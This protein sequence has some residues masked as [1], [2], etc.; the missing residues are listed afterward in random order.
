MNYWDGQQWVPSD[1]TFDAA[2][3]GFVAA[4]VQ[5]P[6][7]LLS[8]LNQIGAVK[9]RTPD[10]I[11]LHSTPV[12]IG[13]YDAASGVS[14]IIGVVKDCSGVLAS[15]NQVVYED[16]FSGVCAD[17]VYTIN[18]GT[19]EQDV[20]ITGRLNPADYG[21]PTNTSRIQIFTEFYDG[22]KPERIRRPLRVEKD[23]AVRSRMA[24][25]DLIDEVL[26]FGE[27]VIGTGKAFT[28]PTFMHTNGVESVVAKE[29]K[30]MAG[31]TF[32][33]ESVEY[34]AMRASL[35]TLPE[36]ELQTASVRSVRGSKADYAA[37][38]PLPSKRDNASASPSNSRASRIAKAGTG[39]RT[40]LVIDYLATL[41]STSSAFTFQGDTTYLVSGLVSLNGPTTIEGGAVVKYQI[42]KS[43]TLTTTST[44][45]CN[46]SSY[47]P[48]IFTAVDDHSVGEQI[49]TGTINPSGY[50]NPA[51]SVAFASSVTLT[52]LQFRYAQESIKIPATGGG[53]TLSHLQLVNCIRGI[54]I[55]GCGSATVTINNSL[56]ANVQ[57]P[58]TFTGS[59]PFANCYNCTIDGYLPVGGT[60]R[61]LTG[62]TSAMA[63]FRNSIIA[64]VNTLS[65]GTVS[66][67]GSSYN[68]F[69]NCG[70]TPFGASQVSPS[71]PPFQSQGAGSYYLAAGHSFRNAGTTVP[72]ALL[73]DLKKKT[74]YP[75]IVLNGSISA[76]TTLSP[77]GQRDTDA[78]DLGYHYDPLDYLLNNVSLSATLTLTN[79]VAVGLQN[80]Y[81]ADMQ[82]G[83]HV[84]S[85]GTPVQMNRVAS[86]ANVQEQPT[87]ASAST[88]LKLNSSSGLPRM[89]F[90]FANLSIGQGKSGTLVD[91]GTGTGNSYPFERLSFRDCTLCNAAITFKP[92]TTS[93]V[94]VAL[95]NNVLDRCKLAI[96][97][98][99]ADGNPNT[100]LT[101][102]LYNNLFRNSPGLP[103][104]PD[105][106]LAL[107]YDFYSGSNPNN[108]TWTARDNL[109]K[110]ASQTLA[111]N[112]QGQALIARSYNGFT[113]GTVNTLAS[114][115]DVTGLTVNF[116]AGGPLGDYYYPASGAY[117]SLAAL[118]NADVG[119]TADLAGL[120]HY[121]TTTAVGTKE[122][123]TLVD[124]GF[125]YLGVNA[126]NQP[127]DTDGDGL[128]DYLEDRDSSGTYTSGD[129]ANLTNVDTDG[130]GLADGY[131]PNPTV[132]NGA[133]GLSGVS[134][135]K[136]PVP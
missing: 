80:S 33:I 97:R 13:L 121:T 54:V 43:V 89:D 50:A 72:A 131:D 85:E 106:A 125:H 48:A 63:S 25:P 110:D 7:H 27:F 86:L 57:Y 73:N 70:F 74:T 62:S 99:T 92:L 23:Q 100:P 76:N 37:I 104:T 136:C 130:D 39:R 108:L 66:T 134:V 28:A 22:N 47:R 113:S 32:L 11:M 64:N 128:P 21:F 2:D 36:C 16:A 127:I 53:G 52:N 122:Q 94:T 75:P 60:S 30:T 42:G 126:S 18:R 79:G 119:R 83:G 91:T 96:S 44:L 40:G 90:R 112:S 58:L 19:F 35:E 24:S 56:M 115:T 118:I 111:G 29:F 101:V 9:L 59:G 135:Q 38:P 3:D 51:L 129:L 98:A 46:T 20:V 31:R 116:V 103:S 1:P 17:V 81:G 109:F 87:V 45:T 55:A 123:N 105:P 93:S 68:G 102:I 8:N 88:F 41:G 107:T 10:G 61:L 14:A 12:G 6:L 124:I 117:P 78:I 82:A 120:Y 114:A 71:G 132:P 49:G 65:S 69:Y 67:S 26:G 4:K 95:T 34:P 15:S 77:Q 84:I 5:H 133:V